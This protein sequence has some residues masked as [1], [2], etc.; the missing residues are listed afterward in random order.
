MQIDPEIFAHQV[1]DDEGN[2]I[3]FVHLADTA[4]GSERWVGYVYGKSPF[5]RI[6]NSTARYVQSIAGKRPKLAHSDDHAHQWETKTLAGEAVE[7]VHQWE[8]E[9]RARGW[10]LR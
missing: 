6:G 5:S 9:R 10:Q 8:K 3:G 4:D 7:A 1:V 2:P